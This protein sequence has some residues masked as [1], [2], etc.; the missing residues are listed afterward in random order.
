MATMDVRME[1]TVRGTDGETLGRVWAM[2]IAKRDRDVVLTH[3]LIE[4][5][6][7]ER[8]ALLPFALV[9]MSSG[10]EIVLRVSKREAL[11]HAEAREPEDSVLIYRN[12]P[13]HAVDARLGHIRGFYADEAGKVSDLLINDEVSRLLSMVSIRAVDEI[14]PHYIQLGSRIGAMGELLKPQQAFY[15]PVELRRDQELY[16]HGH[17]TQRQH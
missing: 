2:L 6:A 12:D 8:D 13:V 15:K 4:G 11:E 14:S 5:G 1:A 3:L 9:G 17:G 10:Q 7:F 16:G